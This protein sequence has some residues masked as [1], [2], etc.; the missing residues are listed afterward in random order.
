MSL[1]K[2]Y[3]PMTKYEIKYSNTFKKSLKRIIKQ[4]KDIDKLLY[5]VEKL[6][7]CEELE[8]KNHNLINDKYYI[9]CGEC[10]IEPDWLLIYQ[11]NNNQLILLLVDTGSHS[12][13]F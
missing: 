4:G 8:Y 5:I 2:N 3:Y 7:N 6:A 9:N 1:R 12:S 11:Y 10:H 13:L